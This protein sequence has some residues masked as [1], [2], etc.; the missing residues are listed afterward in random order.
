M[1]NR[2]YDEIA[3]L[4][5]E[6]V[7]LARQQGGV[8]AALTVGEQFSEIG[9]AEGQRAYLVTIIGTYQAQ[10]SG[11]DTGNI[12]ATKLEGHYDY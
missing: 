6:A 11:S 3:R 9:T 1:F 4:F 2:Q 10:R 12:E 8:F 7:T 5:R